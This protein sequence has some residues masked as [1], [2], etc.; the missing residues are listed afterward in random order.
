MYMTAAKNRMLN[1]L[2]VTHLSA[3]TSYPGT[4]GANEI[5]GSRTALTVAPASGEV[6]IGPSASL[7]IGAGNT[8]GWIGYWNSTEFV[9]LSPNG[10]APKEFFAQVST[11]LVHVAAHGWSDTQPIVFY[12]GTPPSPFVAGTI[13]YVR[14]ATADSFK[15]A[16]TAGGAAI[17]ITSAGT[18][19]CMVSA[20]TE[21]AYASAGTHTV[22][23]ST[24]GLPF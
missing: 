14:D 20:I 3:H 6:A 5:S 7:A 24:F 2:G 19:G 1:S 11:D 16:A 8:V 15:V 17:D 10:G 21:S 22:A 23:N 18:G 9:A 13:Y 4:T 12:G